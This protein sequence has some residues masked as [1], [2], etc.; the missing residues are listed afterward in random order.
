MGEVLDRTGLAA[1]LETAGVAWRELSDEERHH[2][3]VDGV[4]PGAI[5]WPS[6]SQEAARALA[7]AAR[8]GLAVSPRG[9]GTKIGLG[10]PPRACDLIVSTERLTRV[11][12]YAPANL[13]VTAEA[14]MSLAAL[15]ATLAEGS[16]FLPL[17]PPH[18]GRATLGGVIA[19]NASG[20]R[21]F[22]L[23]S[24]RDLVIGTSVATTAGTVTKAGGRVVKNVAGYDLNKL[25]IGSLGTLVL[26]GEI[27][28]KVL[29]K[30]AAQVT[31]VGRFSKIDQ[32][33]Q[34]VQTIVRSPLLPI[35]VDLLNPESASA[36]GHDGLPEARGG[37]LLATLGAAPG[38]ALGRQRDDLRRIYAEAGGSDVATLADADSERFWSK[39]ADPGASPAEDRLSSAK[40]SVPL[41]RVPEVIRAIEARRATFGGRPAIR[42]SAG[43][44]V[45]YLSWSA[46]DDSM[47]N[48]QR[49]SM[50]EGL[51]DLRRACQSLGG[52]LVVEECPRALKDQLDVWGDVGPSLAIMQRLKAALDPRAVMNPGRFV[53]GI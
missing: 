17:D 29:P 14:G 22:G 47:M 8:L 51:V 3:A 40:I 11:I 23:G 27:T 35:A 26:V 9:S 18:A 30:P 6:S 28:F 52:S 41:G 38:R 39:V 31:V 36:L 21:R 44:G 16:Q 2:Y 1:G 42:G 20:P 4:E 33:G 32:L 13:T 45:L 46:S 7:V 15:Q 12:E 43:S 10:N 25:Y 19:A 37:Y 53:G 48:G 5:C 34:A 49:S 24:A 50:V